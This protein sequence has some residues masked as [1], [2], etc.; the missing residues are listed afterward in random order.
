[1]LRDRAYELAVKYHE[2]LSKEIIEIIYKEIENQASKGELHLF[3]DFGNTQINNMEPTQSSII[4]KII[5]NMLEEN[6]YHVWIQEAELIKIDWSIR[7]MNQIDLADCPLP[8]R[9]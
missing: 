1:M 2:K 5:K 3:F 9:D 4:I 7:E 8:V 6:G